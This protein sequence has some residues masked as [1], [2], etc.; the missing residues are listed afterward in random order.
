MREGAASRRRRRDVRVR[1][2]PALQVAGVGLGEPKRAELERELV[3]WQIQ[4][5]CLVGA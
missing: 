5:L 1:V 3:E 2:Q 4:M